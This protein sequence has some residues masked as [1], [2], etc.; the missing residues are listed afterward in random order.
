V[1]ANSLAGPALATHPEV[2]A[3]I[4]AGL[5]MANVSRDGE[6]LV[7]DRLRA[8][9]EAVGIGDRTVTEDL[10]AAGSDDFGYDEEI[11]VFG[12]TGTRYSKILSEWATAII[13][14]PVLKDHDLC[15][16]S[17]AMKNHFGSINNPNKLHTNHCSPHVAD[18]NACPI[19]REKHRLVVFDALTV[20]YDGG[21]GY[22]P[23]TTI[24]YGALIVT[25]D[26]V[27]ADAVALSILEGLR[28]EH[29]L[30]PLGETDRYP[31]YIR[32]AADAQHALGTADL[33]MLDIREMT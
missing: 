2:L 17:G 31:D 16:L 30:T 22:K 8:E 5:D 6:S 9:L 4:S 13:N 32:V 3:A 11:T 15:G 12:E 20:C 23:D 28:A 29:G 21:P 33:D 19:I 18:I 24:P 14:V 25:T 1:K 27:A 10:R 7:Y 26:P